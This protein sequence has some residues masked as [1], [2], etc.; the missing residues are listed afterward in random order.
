MIFATTQG[1]EALF[2]V[3]TAAAASTACSMTAL[4]FTLAATKGEMSRECDRK[5]AISHSTVQ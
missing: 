3:S 2:Q 1:A 4:A 5:R